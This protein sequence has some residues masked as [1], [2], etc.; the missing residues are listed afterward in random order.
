MVSTNPLSLSELKEPSLF[1]WSLDSWHHPQLRVVFPRSSSMALPPFL[2][3]PWSRNVIRELIFV[4]LPSLKLTASSPLQIGKSAPRGNELV[5]QASMKSGANWMLVSGSVSRNFSHK[6]KEISSL[7]F[8][9]LVSGAEFLD[10]G[11]AKELCGEVAR[12]VGKL[13]FGRTI[14]SN[15]GECDWKAKLFFWKFCDVKVAGRL[16]FLGDMK[17]LFWGVYIYIHIHYTFIFIHTWKNMRWA[18]GPSSQ[19]LNDQQLWMIGLSPGLRDDQIC[20]PKGL[21]DDEN[22]P[23]EEIFIRSCWG[24]HESKWIVVESYIISG[25][26]LTIEWL[27]IH[28]TLASSSTQTFPVQCWS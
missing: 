27:L 13:T 14:Q 3:V 21:R 2:V 7:R 1:R 25:L 19:S 23:V 8:E 26:F 18:A 22:G 6:V 9:E 15:L 17:C 11:G 10:Q 12:G 16:E 20:K 5:F 24:D 4:D 28:S